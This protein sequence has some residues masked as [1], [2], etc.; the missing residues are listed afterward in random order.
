[1]TGVSTDLQKL[2]IRAELN[3]EDAA[4]VDLIKENW[5]VLL[6]THYDK[7]HRGARETIETDR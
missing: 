7:E 1:M 3:C 4:M 2:I 5:E 6:G